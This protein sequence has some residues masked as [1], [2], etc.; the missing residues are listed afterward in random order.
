MIMRAMMVCAVLLNVWIQS[1]TAQTY[2]E[3]KVFTGPDGGSPFG[4]LVHSGN[5]LYGIRLHGGDDG[6]GTVF[7]VNTDGR[8]FGIIKSFPEIGG[9]PDYTNSH[10]AYPEAGLAIAGDTL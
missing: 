6:T 3:L 4:D 1:A 5:T 9:F 8:G 2:T 7:K 10:G